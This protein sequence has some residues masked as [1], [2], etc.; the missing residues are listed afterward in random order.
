MFSIASN[1]IIENFI[2]ELKPELLKFLAKNLS[3]KPDKDNIDELVDSS[4]IYV[5]S[6]CLTISGTI[7]SNLFTKYINEYEEEK[8][9]VFKLQKQFLLYLLDS[10]NEDNY[11]VKISRDWIG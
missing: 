6:L 8:E 5:G 7:F 2:K 9:M 4:F 10:L 11:E 1:K 3:K